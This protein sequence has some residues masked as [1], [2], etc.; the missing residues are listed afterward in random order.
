SRE[1]NKW[2]LEFANGAIEDADFICVAS[3]GYPKAAMFEWLTVTGHSIEPPVPSLF[4]FN[5]PGN[6]ITQLMG[7]ATQAKV[8]IQGIKLEEEGAVLITHWGLSGP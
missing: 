1:K 5:M 7:I 2:K 3:G 6:A 8:K 4:T